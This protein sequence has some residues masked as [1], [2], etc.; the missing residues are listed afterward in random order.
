MHIGSSTEE[1]SSPAPSSWPEGLA[2]PVRNGRVLVAAEDP[3][4]RR[5]I[6]RPLLEH[7]FAVVEAG[8]AAAALKFARRLVDVAVVD[9][10]R[11]G[12][13]G[14]EFLRRWQKVCLGRYVLVLLVTVRAAPGDAALH[15]A[16][17]AGRNRVSV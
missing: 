16:K 14:P 3:D 17:A 15:L 7:G 11:S 2:E 12:I 10:D 6:C 1:V 9:V 8:D 13:E 5:Q 4:L